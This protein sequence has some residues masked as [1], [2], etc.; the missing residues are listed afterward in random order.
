MKSVAHSRRSRRALWGVA[1]TVALAGAG[2]LIWFTQSDPPG[3]EWISE[4]GCE[5]GPLA[6]YAPGSW[7][8]PYGAVRSC[9]VLDRDVPRF[10]NVDGSTCLLLNTDRG[11]VAVRVDY[12]NR[13]LGRQMTA[14]AVEL[15]MTDVPG[16]VT[17][18][19]RAVL[20]HAIDDRGGVRAE[21][22]IIDYGDG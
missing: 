22:W 2:A 18:T 13:D 11:A 4:H 21:P 8:Y 9:Q 10:G 6:S 5:E 14:T 15:D 17:A 7:L 19:Q 3:S 20:Q 16:I 12:R 1:I